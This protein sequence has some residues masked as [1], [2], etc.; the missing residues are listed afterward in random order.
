M[1]EPNPTIAAPANADPP[2]V[3]EAVTVA[4]AEPPDPASPADER[5][6]EREQWFRDRF[7]KERQVTLALMR[8]LLAGLSSQGRRI[9]FWRW[10]IDDFRSERR[11]LAEP[12][13]ETGE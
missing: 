13:R 6:R 10:L 1:E 4:A 9:R 8:L 11:I 7:D 3:A 12:D 5:A 2:P